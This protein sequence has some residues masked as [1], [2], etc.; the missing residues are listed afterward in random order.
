MKIEHVLFLS[1]FTK[2]RIRLIE[3]H[4][5]CVYIDPFFGTNKN[6][7][8]KNGSCEQAFGNA[9]THSRKN[10]KHSASLRVS[11]LSFRVSSISACLIVIGRCLLSK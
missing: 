7:I 10:Y 4:F 3:G 9:L 2:L 1:V 8:L 5:Q 6:R 11:K